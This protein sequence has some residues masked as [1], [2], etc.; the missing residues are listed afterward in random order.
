MIAD[1]RVADGAPKAI[2]V[3]GAGVAGLV[4]AY[5]LERLG[6]RVE[7]LEASG[8]IGGRVHTHRF[9]AAHEAPFAEL[10]AMRIRMDH[11]LTQHYIGELGLTGELR[12]F[13]TLFSDEGNL[14][15]THDGGYVRVREAPGVLVDHLIARLGANGYH[16]NT[17][18]FGAWLSACLDAVAPREF[19][20]CPDVST[21]LL[22]LVDR[23]D[24]HPY[25]RGT[26]ESKVDLHAVVADHPHIRSV[27]FRGRERLLDDVLDETSYAL[28]RVRG[29]M[30][31][32]TRRLAERINGPIALGH[33]VVGVSVRGDGVVLQVRHEG[34]T[35]IR[36]CDYVLCTIPF[37]VLRALSLDGFDDEKLD[38][39][40][41][42]RYWP[43]TKIALHCRE[44]FWTEDGITG[45]ASFTGGL[46]RQTYYP[47]VEN[48]P[49]LGAVLLVSYTIGP[50]ADELARLDPATR[51]RVVLEEAGRMHP[52]LLEPGMVLG[53]TSLAWGEHRW[54]KGA[55][56]IRWGQD[57]ATRQEQQW[58]AA[59]SQGSLF[60]AGEHCSSKPAWIEG[61]IESAVNAVHDIEWC[62]N[63]Y[64]SGQ[65]DRQPLGARWRR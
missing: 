22:D 27:F 3:L 49:A 38:V 59:R 33:E 46:V 17:L 28:C 10:G 50:D 24:L 65:E 36:H 18:L 53:S 37:P 13:R 45:G 64:R 60:F 9:G 54:S 4:A 16:R 21:E 15:H 56:A 25:L 44:A 41:Q 14:L 12:D 40:H 39:I 31:V 26:A 30:D 1:S 8:H 6:H 51:Y 61:A 23:I 43:A 11:E 57:T 19:R 7:I 62:G 32:I 52:G 20:D 48:D 55:A 63:F 35:T 47:P 29:G 5:E 2:T 42:T 34:T 58:A